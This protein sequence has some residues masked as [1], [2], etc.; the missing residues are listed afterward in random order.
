MI[1]VIICTFNRALMLEESVRS[2]LNCQTDGIDHELLIIDN[3]STDRT[4]EIAELFAKQNPRI[5]YG[6]EP[7]QNLCHS[8]NRGIRESRGEI[9][10]FVD[11]D[12]RFSPGWFTA[13]ASAFERHVEVACVGG[14]VVPHFEADRPSWLDDDLLWIYGV[15]RYGD[16]EREIRPPE[17][18]IGCNMAFRR[19]VFEQIGGFHPSLGRSG[20]NLQSNDE[21]RLF[22]SVAK[23]GLKTL[24]SPDVQLAHR[25]PPVRMSR[26]WV[27]R[28]HYWEGISNIILRQIDDDPLSR[29]ILTK[30]AIKTLFGLLRRWKDTVG[31]LSARNGRGGGP[32]KKQ[33]DICYKLGTLRQVIAELFSV[34]S[35]NAVISGGRGIVK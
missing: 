5:R 15:T 34:S 3:N 7:L 2:F 14:K 29:V 11:D 23:A 20:G 1:S 25:I 18:P 19:V 24:Y 22:V 28:R 17:T 16:H 12:V 21:N 13:L 31:L 10:V 33:L 8:R 9:V 30:Q 4:R 32:I 26:S 35:R 27:L 6:F